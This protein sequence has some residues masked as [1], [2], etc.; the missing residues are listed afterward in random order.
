M[1]HRI[2]AVGL[3]AVFGFLLA[4]DALACGDKFLVTSRGTRYQ[5]PKDARAAS[6]LIYANP[7]SGLPDTLKKVRV[8]S[9]LK[10]QGH[11]STTVE[12]IEQ[13]TAILA[14]GRFDVVLAAGSVRA[15]VEQLLGATPDAAV[16]VAVDAPPKERSLLQA[17]DKAVEQ[18]DKSLRKAQTR[19]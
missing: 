4:G 16:L 2:R 13:L 12:T 10:K 19:S 9:V 7:T 18:R 6:I 1:P 8:E 14:S 11:R 15:A 3:A 17:I 5:R